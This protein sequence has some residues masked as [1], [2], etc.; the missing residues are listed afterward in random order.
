MSTV[1]DVDNDNSN[2]KIYSTNKKIPRTYEKGKKAERM[3][4]IKPAD[5]NREAKNSKQ[6]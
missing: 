1:D 3:L 4:T 5:C 2:D 6:Y